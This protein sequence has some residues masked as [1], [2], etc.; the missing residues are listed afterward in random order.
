MV[1][2]LQR[3]IGYTLCGDAVERI[4]VEMYGPTGS[5]G[6]STLLRVMERLMGDYGLEGRLDEEALGRRRH[7][8]SRALVST[9]TRS[10][11]H[12]QVGRRP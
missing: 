4:M 1:D 10:Q 3:L 6:K 8:R 5:N 7:A 2:F 9:R 11:G 12:G